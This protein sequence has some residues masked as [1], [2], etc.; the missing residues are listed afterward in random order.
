MLVNI[1]YKSF[2]KVFK[3]HIIV[4]TIFKFYINMK[5]T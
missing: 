1:A 4:F 2:L 5:Y 3:N